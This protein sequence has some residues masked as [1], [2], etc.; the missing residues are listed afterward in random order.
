MKSLL[1]AI[2]ALALLVGVLSWGNGGCE[3]FWCAVA[4]AVA[5]ARAYNGK[6]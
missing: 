4:G 3:A 1:I 2:D 6:L 5:L